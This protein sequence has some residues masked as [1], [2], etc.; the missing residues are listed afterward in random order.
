[1]FNPTLGR[2]MTEDPI[3]YE[4]GNVNLYGY[5]NNNPTN[6]VDPSGLEPPP[7]TPNDPEWKRRYGDLKTLPYPEKPKLV[8]AK[9]LPA[10]YKDISEIPDV[11]EGEWEITLATGIGNSGW[12]PGHA[13]IILKSIDGKTE[14]TINDCLLEGKMNINKD[15]GHK[16]LSASCFKAKDVRIPK[17][18]L[19][20]GVTCSGY[21]VSFWQANKGPGSDILVFYRLTGVPTC[22]L[23]EQVFSLTVSGAGVVTKEPTYLPTNSPPQSGSGYWGTGGEWVDTSPPVQRPKY[24]PKEH[25]WLNDPSPD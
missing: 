9:T 18:S 13:W 20:T 21:A 17:P 8:C 7:A 2:W 12:Y 25:D 5:V 19:L 6:L 22:G 15:F 4:G 3:D 24:S 16:P 1:M 11:L 23:T 14:Y 10:T